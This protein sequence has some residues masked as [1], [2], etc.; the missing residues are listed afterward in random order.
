MQARDEVMGTG[1]FP[2]M[3]SGRSVV[4]P[5][6]Q[7]SAPHSRAAVMGAPNAGVRDSRRDGT[8]QRAA[9]GWA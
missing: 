2:L 7:S 1:K 3:E 9:T 8:D 6:H 4:S 5:L